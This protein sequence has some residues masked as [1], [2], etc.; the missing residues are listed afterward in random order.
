MSLKQK[1][2]QESQ[3]YCKKSHA[4]LQKGSANKRIMVEILYLQGLN[5]DGLKKKEKCFSSFK[6]ARK[7]LEGL[8]GCEWFRFFKELI[9]EA[10][11]NIN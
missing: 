6:M 7:A 8:E 11:I 1:R 3:D 4:L 2:F 5:Y 9:D 10:I